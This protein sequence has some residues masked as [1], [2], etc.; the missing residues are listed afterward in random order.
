[1]ADEKKNELYPIFDLIFRLACVYVAAS[2]FFKGLED[3]RNS[4]F[5][6]VGVDFSLVIGELGLIFRW[7]SHKSKIIKAIPIIAMG[8]CFV[9]LALSKLL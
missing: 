1:M 8:L 5:L 2:F 3:W 6:L 9:F 7:Y 4:E